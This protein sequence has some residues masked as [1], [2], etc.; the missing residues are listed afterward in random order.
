[1]EF[2]CCNETKER[3]GCL[4]VSNF[5]ENVILDAK[6]ILRF[7]LSI[8]VPDDKLSNYNTGGKEIEQLG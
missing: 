5:I 3:N 7:V 8:L 6:S 1:M 4:L 2:V